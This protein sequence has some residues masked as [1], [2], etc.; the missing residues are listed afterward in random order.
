MKRET[1][2]GFYCLLEDDIDYRRNFLKSSVIL[3]KANKVIYGG[4]YYDLNNFIREK[5]YIKNRYIYLLDEDLY[6]NKHTFN[7]KDKIGIRDINR[8]IEEEFG[9]DDDYLFDYITN[10]KK[11]KLTIYAIKGGERV[12]ILCENARKVRVIPIQLQMLKSIKRKVKDKSFASIF[13]YKDSYYYISVEDGVFEKSFVEKNLKDFLLRFKDYKYKEPLYLDS[14]IDGIN[15]KNMKEL[16][17]GGLFN[18]K[19][20]YKEEVFA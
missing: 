10:R 9:L 7:K 19:I 16:D 2:Y 4:T 15:I 20:L 6:I 5:I 3:I 1:A 18:D 12:S 14:R 17:F 11:T 8:I 13:I